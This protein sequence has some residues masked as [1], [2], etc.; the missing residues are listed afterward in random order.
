MEANGWI[1]KHAIKPKQPSLR[2]VYV[3][4]VGKSE[5][6]WRSFWAWH[7]D[8]EEDEDGNKSKSPDNNHSIAPESQSSIASPPTVAHIQDD[9]ERVCSVYNFF[10][11]RS[12]P[13]IN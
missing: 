3:G 12:E 10:L 5:A 8:E 2:A 13:Q 4:S 6:K 1:P 9:N 11:C 7:D